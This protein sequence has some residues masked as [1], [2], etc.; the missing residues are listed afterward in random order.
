TRQESVEQQGKR[1]VTIA[2]ATITFKKVEDLGP[3]ADLASLLL[4]SLH[5]YIRQCK[6]F[7]RVQSIVQSN[8]RF[9]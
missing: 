2:I 5:V 8:F 3:R 1:A 9:H 4:Y 7:T 6:T